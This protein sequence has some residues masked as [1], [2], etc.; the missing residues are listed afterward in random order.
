[1][2]AAHESEVQGYG[3]AC[4]RRPHAKPYPWTER[5]H[6][7]DPLQWLVPCKFIATACA[8]Q[9]GTEGMWHVSAGQTPG[10]TLGKPLWFLGKPLQ[11]SILACNKY[12]T[13][14]QEACGGIRPSN[15]IIRI[16]APSY[17]SVLT[18]AAAMNLAPVIS[19]YTFTIPVL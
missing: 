7:D 16:Q 18:P 2:Q 9:A 15:P 11:P 3:F 19:L 5:S 14:W 1:M 8:M 6:I 10:Q 13:E 12:R 4:G 17:A